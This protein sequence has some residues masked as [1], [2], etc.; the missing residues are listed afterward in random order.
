MNR[1]ALYIG[2]L[3][4]A[5]G[6]AGFFGPLVAGNQDG[7]INVE[8]GRL[9]GFLATNWAHAGVHVAFGLWGISAARVPERGRTYLWAVGA[10]FGAAALLGFLAQTGLMVVR[11]PEGTLLVLEMAVDTAANVLHL[12]LAAVALGLTLARGGKHTPAHAG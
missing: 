11:D 10:L 4:L 2:I 1:T 12:G 6:L 7:L 9:F 8:A 3:N 5:L